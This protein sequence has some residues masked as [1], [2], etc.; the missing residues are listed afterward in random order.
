MK[1]S[2]TRLAPVALM[3]VL[4]A[5]TFWLDRATQDDGNGNNGKDR[6]DPDYMVYNFEVRRFNADG[7][8]Q[9]AVAA[10]E[11]KHYPDDD[12]TSVVAPRVTYYRAPPLYLAADTAWLDKGGKHVRLDGNVRVTRTAT[13]EAPPTLIETSILYVEPDDEFAHTDAPV[14]ITQDRSVING[15]GMESNNKTH[16]SVLSGPVKGIIYP[17]QKQ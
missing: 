17:K 6:H 4:A 14:T 1:H 16:I 11:M 9:H 15:V 3:A 7:E 8:L 5:L 13:D 2:G 10:P 12:S